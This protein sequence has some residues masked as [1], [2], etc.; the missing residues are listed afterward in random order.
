[1]IEYE[2]YL[3]V[4]RRRRCGLGSALLLCVCLPLAQAVAED[5]L[6]TPL[7]VAS[8][9]SIINE[10]GA[11]IEGDSTVPRNQ[12]PLVQVLWATNGVAPPLLSGHPNPA[13]NTPVENAESSIGTLVAPALLNE[14][15]F[16]VSIGQPRPTQEAPIVVRVYNAPTVEDSLFYTDS[17]NDLV[18]SDSGD[19]LFAYFGPMTNIIDAAR[20][21][22]GDGLPDYWE[23]LNYEGN[24][25]GAVVHVDDDGDGMT[26]GDEYVAGTDPNDVLSTFV[27]TEMQHI[28]EH[29]EWSGTRLSWS[30]AAG[31]YYRIDYTT[32][33]VTGDYLPLTGALNRAASPPTNVFINTEVYGGDRP[34]YYR[35]RV[36]MTGWEE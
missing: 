20:D 4:R 28:Y 22:D 18:V 26:A 25:T 27:I 2:P 23:H 33:L 24:H 36:R 7:Q 29:G 34:I 21:T 17:T 19:P 32:N 31:R 11:I 6:A 12:R 13:Y 9:A 35:A 1:M 3:A 5:G 8:G 10:F 15:L 14:G 30:S 16:G